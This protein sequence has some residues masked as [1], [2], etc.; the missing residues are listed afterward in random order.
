M[1]HGQLLVECAVCGKT[2]NL[3]V[4]LPA[5]IENVQ[6]QCAVKLKLRGWRSLK[7]PAGPWICSDDLD[8]VSAFD[9]VEVIE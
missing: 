3:D 2:A 6:Q 4:E 8:F 7:G 1:T 9:M 5:S